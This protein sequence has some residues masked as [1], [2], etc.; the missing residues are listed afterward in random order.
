MIKF[1]HHIRQSLISQNQMSKYF[2]YAIGEILLVVIGILMALQ[3]NNWNEQRKIKN[4]EIAIL[5]SFKKTINED[6]EFLNAS[7]K[8]YSA[9]RNS[10]DYLIN[11]IEQ[12]L[13]YIDSLKFHF[14]NL[15]VLHRLAINVS[16]F[17]NLKSKGFDLISNDSLK[18]EII[19]FYDFAQNALRTN[20]EAYRQIIDNGSNT[21]YRKH[22]DAFWEPVSRELYSTEESPFGKD[23][24]IVVMQPTNYEHL[25]KDKEFMYYLKSLRN[26]QYW[27]I[28]INVMKIQKDLTNILT[29]IDRE[30]KE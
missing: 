25:K 17:E 6:F 23:H 10:I 9:S 22:F 5:K 20:F 29:L 16:V 18:E 7:L 21:V 13:P 14:G 1:F 24:L 11:H 12:D 4:Q 19:N 26:Q 2:K 28:T 27:Y 15:N 3:I 8:R 30:L